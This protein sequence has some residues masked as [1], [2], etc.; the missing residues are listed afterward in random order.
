MNKKVYLL[1]ETETEK[2]ITGIFLHIDEIN[3]IHTFHTLELPNKNN[4]KNISCIPKGEY[5][6]TLTYSPHFNKK[7]YEIL[8]VKNRTGIR[9]HATNCFYELRGC[10]AVGNRLYDINNDKELDLLESKKVIESFESILQKQPFTLI[11]I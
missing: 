6:C 2:Q 11:I 4:E 1:R 5:C 8:N 3:K 7:T 10:I 9:I